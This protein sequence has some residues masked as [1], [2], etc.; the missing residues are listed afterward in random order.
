MN[1]KSGLLLLAAATLASPTFAQNKAKVK[2]AKSTVI[3]N[4]SQMDVF[5]DNLMKKMTLEEKIGQLNLVTP[6]GA[7]TGSVVSSDVD[8]K[9]KR[10]EV[11]GL[12]GITGAAKIRKAQEIAVN[13][14]RLK[15]PLIFGLDVIHGHRTI[16]PIPLGLS[17]SWDIPMIQQS[18]QVAAKEATADGLAWVFSPMVDISRDPRW[19]R[20]SEGS[21]EDPYLGSEIAKAM[22]KGYQGDDLSKNNTV[23]A[24]V[25]HFALY[26]AAEAGRD[27]NSTDM[28]RI[29]MFQNFL[30][31]YKAAVDAGVGS[32]MTSF[33]EVDGVPATANKW[34]MTDLLRKQWGFKGMV[35]TDYTAINEMI[36]HGLGDLQQV[37]AESLKAGVDMDMVGE[38]FLT[39]LQKSLK[40]GKVTVQQ[41]ENACRNIL[42][43]KYKLGLFDDPYRYC[44]EKRAGDIFTAENRAAARDYATRS[45]VLLKNDNVLP[46]KKSGSI[47]LVGPL[48]NNHNNMLGTWSVSGDFVNTVSVLQGIQNVAGNVKINYAKGANI[49]DDPEFAK[50]VNAFMT[51]IEIDKRP[52]QEMIDEAVAAAQ[53]SDV[54]VAVLGES[55]NMSGEASSMSNIDLQ[56]SQKRLL[57]ALKKT[58]KPIVIVLMNGRPM[59][60]A[61]EH[62]KTNAILD[63]WF[64]GTEAGNAVA[65]LLFGD[66]IP[67]GKLTA[68]FP[69]NVGQIPIYYNHKNTGRPYV[70]GGPTKFKSNYLDISNDPLYE[71]GY[72]LSYTTFKYSPVTLSAK[73]MTKTGSIKASVTLSN[74]GNYDAEEVVQ[75]YIR[76]MAG[77]VARPVKELKG[78]QKVFLKKG[79]SKEISFTITE[80]QLKFFNTELKYVSEPGAFKVF[81]GTSSAT[82]NE[83]DFVLN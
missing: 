22:I 11:G 6:G 25:K 28:S 64:S 68:T 12:F 56:P 5:I 4:K 20:I 54:V 18:A 75:L 17:C 32:V 26:G 14:S 49:S 9:I 36:D 59:T 31:P 3:V 47:A 40:E 55:A 58:G 45:A 73:N 10:G 33:N 15:I 42:E 70:K 60:I 83:A 38:G 71:F 24:C 13:N 7:V 79:E 82:T 80:E 57:D 2:V 67:S 30:P 41:I 16:F 39:T 69:M 50:K 34:L 8:N 81:I 52:A 63:V 72:G 61:E 76:D 53:K 48:A 46:L 19:G 43:A 29:Q 21:G 23:M 44:D 62:Q 66:K 74:T 65:D 35:V 37:S 27:Y 1:R 78:F 51:E 77:S